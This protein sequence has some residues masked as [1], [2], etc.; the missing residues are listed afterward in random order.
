MAMPDKFNSCASVTPYF[1][2]TGF[3]GLGLALGLAFISAWGVGGA[4]SIS[5]RLRRRGNG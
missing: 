5:K 4:F 3:G 2:L 1:S